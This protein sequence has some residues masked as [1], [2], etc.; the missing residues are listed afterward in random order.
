MP[1]KPQTIHT[2]VGVAVLQQNFIYKIRPLARLAQGP[3]FTFWLLNEIYTYWVCS[4]NRQSK[5]ACNTLVK[6]GKSLKIL[7]YIFPNGRW[8][9]S[10]I[11]WLSDSSRLPSPSHRKVHW[12]VV[13]LGSCP[14]CPSIMHLDTLQWK[15]MGKI[16]ICLSLMKKYTTVKWKRQKYKNITFISPGVFSLRNFVTNIHCIYSWLKD[17]SCG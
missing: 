13:E 10:H 14:G 12:G 2:S 15:K 8:V 4:K 1:K 7:L 5:T 17:G 9:S 3:Y 6:Y 11:L 16:Y